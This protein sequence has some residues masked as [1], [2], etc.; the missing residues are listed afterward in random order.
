MELIPTDSNIIYEYGVL[1]VENII[2]H[3]QGLIGHNT[4]QYQNYVKMYHLNFN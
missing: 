2:L 4:R 3:N 1:T